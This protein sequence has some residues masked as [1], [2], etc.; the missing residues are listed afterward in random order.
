MKL[1]QFSVAT[2]NLYNLQ[3]ARRCHEPE[4]ATV[5]DGRVRRQ[6]HLAGRSTDQPERRRRRP[7]GAAGTATPWS[8]CCG[9]AGLSDTYDLLADP[10]TGDRIVCA[11]LVR[12][13]LLHGTPRVGGPVPRRRAPGVDRGRGPAGTRRSP[14][15]S[16]GSR[17][18]CCD[19]QIELRDDRPA[20]EVFV[21]HLKSKLPDRDLQRGLVSP[22]P[23]PLPSPTPPRSGPLC[24]R[25]GAPRRPPVCVSCSPRS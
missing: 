6:G 13:G 1:R 11:A 10:A 15:R 16:P 12:R 17:G 2:V 18:P 22:R 24:P 25:S 9:V 7:A 14:S 19:F 23:G 20:T 5:D 21:T 8:R 4:P 3:L